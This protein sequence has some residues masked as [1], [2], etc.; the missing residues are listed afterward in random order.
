MRR[1]LLLTGLILFWVIFGITQVKAEEEKKWSFEVFMGSA[2]NLITPLKIR[3]TGYEDIKLNARYETK[4][5]KESPY[6][7]WRISHWKEN[8]AWEL[9]LIHHKL[10]LENRPPEVEHFEITHGYNLLTINRAWERGLIYRLGIGV[11]ISH[12][13]TTIRGKRF[14]ANEG[15]LNHG[16][17]ISGP[18][19][20]FAVG[21]RLYLSK[22]FFATIEGKITTSYARIPVVD[23]KAEVPN[24]GL[25][26]L[27]G[28]GYDF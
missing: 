10:Y 20:Q 11:V 27:F 15:L 13:E 8:K 26:G 4:P 18:T 12:P 14:P 25:H 23:G 2:Y 16:F 5:L 9:E 19:A 22:K 17:Y 3:Q 1:L 7:S 28:L 6:Y 24:V 21:K